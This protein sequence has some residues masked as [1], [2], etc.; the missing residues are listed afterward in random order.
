VLQ[1]PIARERFCYEK[2]FRKK[3]RLRQK[4][5]Q[6]T[7]N[8]TKIINGA[9]GFAH[10]ASGQIVLVRHVLPGE[11][12]TVTIDEEKKKY[13]LGHVR[14]IVIPHPGRRTPPCS[15]AGEC[16]GCDL[17][18]VEYANQ[19]Q[20][21]RGVVMDLLR[22]SSR[23]ELRNA[24]ALLADPIPAPEEFGYRQRLRLQVNKGG[25]FG[26]HRFKSHILIPIKACPLATATLN[27]TLT[28]LKMEPD[29]RRLTSLSSEVELQENPRTG[30]TVIIFR[31]SRK[32]RPT[33]IL[34]AERF[35]R[36]NDAVE[37]VFFA[38]E[39]FAL[40]G[41]YGEEDGGLAGNVL[42]V[43]YP[44]FAG[45]PRELHLSWEAGGFCQVNLRQNQSLIE[46][47]LDFCR[48]KK[49]QRILDLYCGMGNFAVPLALLGAEV[50]G[51]EG[52]GSAIRSAK[53]NA[54]RAGCVHARFQQ[55]PIHT[56]CS[57]LL[58]NG[59]RFDCVV[60]DP[61]RQG[62]PDLAGQ[63]AA[64]T[65]GRLV[66]ISCDPAT[67]CRDIADLVEHGFTIRKIQPIDM[68]PQTHHIETVVLLEK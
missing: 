14:Q 5:R 58:A 12:V 32:P 42:A 9:Y 57:E 43:H 22:R 30:K 49:G 27:Q 3:N 56:A 55:S 50:L 40:M 15:S 67:L 25:I 20:I 59:A 61:P 35:A 65:S 21:K 54:A 66:Y 39:Q 52:Q 36:G 41:P 23:E 62:A 2:I 29:G 44:A 53:N 47:V 64:F 31:L 33:D 63:L 17:Q 7:I 11:Y 38:G 18:H 10:L 51:I 60:I 37:R 24:M 68:F 1:H 4:M 16:G 48:V 26:F 8:I 6:E 28:A 45:L 19:L 46:T 34:A 13:L